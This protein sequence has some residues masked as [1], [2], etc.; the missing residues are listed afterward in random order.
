[1]PNANAE[2]VKLADRR[3]AR[4]YHPDVNGDKEA[5]LKMQIINQAYNQFLLQKLE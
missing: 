4:Q 1:M 5:V 3:L 2:T